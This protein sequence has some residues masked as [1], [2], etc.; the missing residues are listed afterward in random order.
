MET[1]GIKTKNGNTIFN[2]NNVEL[3]LVDGILKENTGWFNTKHPETKN[4]KS[5]SVEITPGIEEFSKKL[6]VVRTEARRIEDLKKSLNFKIKY[7]RFTFTKKRIETVTKELTE[8]VKNIY[9]GK[10]FVTNS[11]RRKGGYF[12]YST[13]EYSGIFLEMSN[14][15]MY[16]L[17][18]G[19]L[20]T[21]RKKNVSYNGIKNISIDKALELIKNEEKADFLKRFK[22]S[23]TKEMISLIS[24][25]KSIFENEINLAIKLFVE[26]KIN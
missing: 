25:N 7:P 26:S 17:G 18:K 6:Y 5:I 23:K 1:Q 15:D 21:S 24:E 11:S 10:L 14:G 19:F 2:W 16:H 22:D 8:N 13:E 4:C 3:V 20:F 12:D 9:Y